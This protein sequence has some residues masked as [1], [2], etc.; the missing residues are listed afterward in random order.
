MPALN[1]ALAFDKR[2]YGPV[3]IGQKLNLDD[4]MQ[5]FQLAQAARYTS[6]YELANDSYRAALKL[7][8][9]LTDIGVHWADLFSRK[10]ASELAAQTLEEVFKVNP[11]HPDAHAAMAG[12]I[13]ETSYDLAAVRHHLDTALKL[14]PKNARALRVRASI[15]IDRHRPFRHPLDTFLI[16]R[17]SAVLRNPSSSASAARRE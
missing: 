14:N 13:I 7:N 1:G 11:N 3:L 12:V 4:P 16:S 9:K 8:P 17:P 5:L 6:Q 15:E 10:Y 2:Q